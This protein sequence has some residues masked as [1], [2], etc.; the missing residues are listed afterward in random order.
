MSV[1][2]QALTLSDVVGQLEF[3][4]PFLCGVMIV[5]GGMLCGRCGEWRESACAWL[6]FMFWR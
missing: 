2:Y 4:D 3:I 1:S 6:G 5:L